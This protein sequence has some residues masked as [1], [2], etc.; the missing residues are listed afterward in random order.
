MSKTK[1]ETYY[2]RVSWMQVEGR[3]R[4]PFHE[5]LPWRFAALVRAWAL[6][7]SRGILAVTVQKYRRAA[8]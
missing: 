4:T 3:C 5:D 7:H 6:R 8:R 1:K 2:W